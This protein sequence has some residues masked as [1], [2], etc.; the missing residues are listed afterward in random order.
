VQRLETRRLRSMLRA[1]PV[2]ALVSGLAVLGF[3]QSAR[4]VDPREARDDAAREVQSVRAEVLAL[5]SGLSAR[6]RPAHSTEQLLAA[7]DLSLRSKD[8]EQAIDTLNQVVEL[9]RQGKASVNAHADG[10]FLLAESYFGAGQWLSAGRQY[11]E[12][13]DLG[14]RSPYDAYAGRS[15]ARLVDVAMHEGRPDVLDA[16]AARASKLTQPDPSG[17]LDYGRG[18]LAFARGRFDESERFLR[19]VPESSAQR[20]QALYLLGTVLLKRRLA[21]LHLGTSADA[22]AQLAIDGARER[23]APAVAQFAEVTRLPKDTPEHRDVIDAAWLAIGR[24]HYE[25]DNYLDAA[26]AYIQVTQGSSAYPEMLFELAWVYVRMGDYERA[27]RALELLSA[28]APDTLD[29]ADGALLR[30]DLMLRS[31]RFERALAAYEEVRTRFDAARER[32]DKFLASTTDPAL[33]YDRLVEEGLAIGGASALPQVVLDWVREEA[34]GERVFNVIDDVTRAR[35][36]LRRSR[37]LASKLN[38]VLSAASRAKAFPELEA[39]LIKVI[40]LQNQLCQARRTLA[41]GFDDIE[42]SAFSGELAEVRRARRDLMDQVAAIP[43]ATADFQRREEEGERTW[44]EVSQAL[45]R[46]TLETDKLQAVV[47]GLK[48]VLD[49]PD[50]H[51]VTKNAAG[52]ARFQAEVEANEQELSAYRARI[53][54]YRQQVENGRVQVGLG[55]R[56][57][58]EDAAV[59]RHFRQL[60]AREVELLAAR[61]GGNASLDYARAVSPQLSEIAALEQRLDAATTALES[62]VSSGSDELRRQV[63][64]E[65]ERLARYA[66][67]L[68]Q[69]DEQSRRLVGEVAMKNFASVRERLKGIVL[70]ADVGIVQQAWELREEQQARLRGLQRQRALEEKNLEDEL[71]EVSDEAGEG[72]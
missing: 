49:Q 40:G 45:Q 12:L 56:R 63:T 60:Q 13:V 57:Y 9:H 2:L 8:Y 20:H 27:E 42:S 39:S 48:Q 43:V 19:A 32:V 4:A 7:G 67:Q 61:Q 1:C 31:G 58:A 36:V 24:L 3:E 29:V 30:A 71:R 18:K 5:S 14:D 33:Y 62:E 15:L 28:V 21:D 50:K 64:E 10:L 26:Q 52:R 59:R 47:N 38:A 34:R 55:D 11:L 65:S 23:L 66:E 37:Q 54:A 72:P 25:S 69:L 6:Q 70:R 53:E 17:A 51:G 44:N 46:A 16:I 22:R 35:D 68:D 41:L